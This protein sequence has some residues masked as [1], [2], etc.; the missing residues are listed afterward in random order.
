MRSSH[1]LGVYARLKPGV[2]LQTAEAEQRMIFG[3][4]LKRFPDD[5]LKEDGEFSLV[6]L[7]EWLV[8][9]ISSVLA[10][11]MASVGFVLLIACANV[12]NLLLARWSARQQEMGVRSALGASRRR[13]IR[14][15]LTESLVLAAIGGAGG[16]LVATWLL[17]TVLALSPGSV[18]EVHASISWPVAIFALIASV[19]TGLLFGCVPALQNTRRSLADTLR[20]GGRTAGGRE[21]R[22]LRRVLVIT[23]FA[24]SLALLVGA[25]LMIRSFLAL[26]GVDPGFRTT[27]LQTVRLDLPVARYPT[28]P[29]QALFFDRFLERVRDLPGVEQVTAAGRLPFAG[30]NSTRGITI[31]GS[32]V[33][34]AWGG[35]RVIGPDYFEIMGVK[36][37]EGRS[38]TDRDRDGGPRVGLV[39]QAMARKYWP[40]G[41]LGRRFRIDTGPWI[42]IVGVV[43]NTKHGSL[44]DPIDPEFYQ[45]YRQAPWTF[46]T[47][48]IRSTLPA[49]E[50]TAGLGRQL[51]SLDSTLAMPPARSMSDLV[52]GSVA[53]DRFEMS[54]LVMFAGLALLLASI[55]LY[56]VMAHLVGQRSKELGLRMALGASQGSILRTILFDGMG[57]VAVGLAG[58][59]AMAFAVTRALRQTLFGVSAADPATFIAVAVILVT[60][61][62]LACLVPARRATRV[63][64]MTA[65]RGD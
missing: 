50:L 32:S 18:R 20:S 56:G 35:I 42:E 3:R 33:A 40:G 47:V 64:P 46:M 14:Q 1:Y 54:G 19:A 29:Q 21:G 55:G 27:G 34:D 5:V 10:I 25:G 57:L 65:V 41:A 38:I 16:L 9:D 28:G 7:R 22:R 48:V 36:V 37:L 62:L 59:C 44:R 52:S 15:L 30:G 60:V 45:P 53:M 51:A 39:N 31:D 6:P 58:G 24:V 11:L 26:R 12:A 13:I 63:D 61:A 23:E 4:L 49:A 43:G 2:S 17:P 8:G